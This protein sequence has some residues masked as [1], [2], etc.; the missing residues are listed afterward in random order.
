MAQFSQRDPRWAYSLLGF[1]PWTIGKAGCLLTC[2]AAMVADWGVD[3]D[4]A[5]LNSWL[6]ATGGFVN[7]GLLQFGALARLDAQVIEYQDCTYTP[8]PV[9]RMRDALSAG[10][11]VF[12]AVDWSPG[13]AVQTHW[14]RVLALDD[15]DGQVMDPWQMPGGELVPLATYLAPGWDPAR[16][17][18]EVL[19][20]R[21]AGQRGVDL[22]EHE[23][24]PPAQAHQRQLYLH[25]TRV[26]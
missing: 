24:S 19:F 20:Y 17:I 7:G 18:F 13:D 15:H 6:C 26:A 12:A 16:G 2:A 22:Q 1:S 4:P 14:V 25:P 21:P 5:R 11:A 23:A 8:A 3:T 9:E 10:S